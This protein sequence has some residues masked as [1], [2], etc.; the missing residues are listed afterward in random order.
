VG[1]DER[2][3]GPD[4]DGQVAQLAVAAFH[5]CLLGAH[6]PTLG[7]KLGRGAAAIIILAGIACLV[8][9]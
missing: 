6:L 4:G 2:R 1:D 8:L 3:G 9:A 5:R 7:E